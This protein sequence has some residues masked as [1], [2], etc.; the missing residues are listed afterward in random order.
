MPTT[1]ASQFPTQ[2]VAPH[3]GCAM[4]RC[5]RG[6]HHS[7]IRA[8]VGSTRRSRTLL[9][10]MHRNRVRPKPACQGVTL[11]PRAPF[12]QPVGQ[13][14]RASRNIRRVRSLRTTE[15]DR[16]REAPRGDGPA[17]FPTAH[18]ER[19][20]RPGSSESALQTR[21]LLLGGGGHARTI[22]RSRIGCPSSVNEKLTLAS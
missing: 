13:A 8:A 15:P 11:L 5:R 22:G 19:A 7:C 16:A 3:L 4:N 17:P 20:Q 10:G 2:Q 9:T 12:P 14:H 18:G 21:V 6:S 1:L